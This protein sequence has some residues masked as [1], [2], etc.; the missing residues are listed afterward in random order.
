M[1]RFKFTLEAVQTVR[2]RS[3]RGALETYAR[4]LRRRLECEAALEKAERA[5]ASHLSEWR[6][7]MGKSFAPSDM[8]QNE[9]LRAMLEAHRA[10][11]AKVLRE[12]AEAAVKA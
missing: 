8:L 6:G 3:A 12:A 7:A 9:Q 10:E 1:K 4:A 5:L 11:C 2:E